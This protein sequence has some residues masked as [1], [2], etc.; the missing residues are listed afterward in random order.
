[1]VEEEPRDL[2]PLR[3]PRA[4]SSGGDHLLAEVNLQLPAGK[5]GPRLILRQPLTLAAWQ[6]DGHWVVSSDEILVYG[7]APTLEAA[8]DDYSIALKEYYDLLRAGADQYPADRLQFQRLQQ[9]LHE[10]HG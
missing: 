9:H 4:S 2:Q 6:D 8:I 7:D 5:I 3:A 10:C 1:M